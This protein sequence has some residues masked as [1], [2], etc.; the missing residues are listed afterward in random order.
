[1]L[2]SFLL[3]GNI[4]LLTHLILRQFSPQFGRLVSEEARRKGYLRFVHSR[5]ITNS[6]E[7]GF[8]R[9][10]HI[11][12]SVL[13]RAFASLVAQMNVLSTK[14]LWYVMLEQL[15]MKYLW[16]ATG[17]VVIAMPVM[18]SDRRNFNALVPV[19]ARRLLARGEDS[20][21]ASEAATSTTTSPP[22]ALTV[23]DI[24]DRTEY[25]TTA[26]NI[27][28][29]GSDALERLLSSYKEV[30]ELA[31]YT[32]RVAKMFTVFE[33]VSRGEFRRDSI[34]IKANGPQ[35]H[36]LGS[37]KRPV[38]TYDADGR[39][40]VRGV[41]VE[42]NGYIH[43]ENVPVVTPNCEVVVK[44]LTLTVSETSNQLC[45]IRRL[46]SFPSI[47]ITTRSPTTCIC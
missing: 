14:R 42:V 32:E 46:I 35:Q 20:S 18:L 36:C 34:V 19:F 10:G 9:G 31:G 28:I 17:M 29:S 22:A 6:E 26:K 40:E 25:M 39:P 37:D 1:M 45:G 27:L 2:M 16:S 4:V 21:K 12:R 7:I 44:D 13:E 30:T 23:D 8:Y 33:Q 24:S 41:V 38:L 5:V 15:L 43:L 11:E 3:A 47:T